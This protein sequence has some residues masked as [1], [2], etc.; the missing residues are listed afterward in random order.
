[1]DVNASV[2]VV[3]QIPADVVGILVDHEIVGAVPAPIGTNGPVP[4]RYLKVEAARKPEAVMIGIEAFD[5]V[6]VRRAKMF[7]PAM[8]EGMI[9]VEALVIRT[10]V[11]VPMILVDVRRA[12]HMAGH[13][14]L[15]L[16]LGVWVVS[17]LGWR[18][19]VALIGAGRI[20]PALLAMFLSA[21][22]E[23]R[24]RRKYC[25]SNRKNELSFHFHLLDQV[26]ITPLH[27]S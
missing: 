19:D 15:G 24:E 4:G 9:E 1:V 25:Q 21:L 10:I 14:A 11:A 2:N 7:K 16:G 20:L 8:L 13:M 22:R 18:R 17:P 23:N 27:N 26:E 12:I 6:A 3:K 5:A